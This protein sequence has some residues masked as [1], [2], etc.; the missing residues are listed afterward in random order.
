MLHFSGVVVMTDDEC[1][2]GKGLSTGAV[3]SDW[4]G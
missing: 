4:S 1:G 2:H 3:E